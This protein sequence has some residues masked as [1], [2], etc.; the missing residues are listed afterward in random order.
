MC[1]QE[2]LAVGNSD[3]SYLTVM[4]MRLQ[5]CYKSYSQ[6]MYGHPIAFAKCL[7]LF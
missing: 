7:C 4:F 2:V 5:F 3:V 1:I 6:T